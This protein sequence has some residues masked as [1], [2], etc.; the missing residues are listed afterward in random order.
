MTLPQSRQ[1]RLAPPLVSRRYVPLLAG[2]IVAAC[3]WWVGPLAVGI[4]T[5]RN[6]R[7]KAVFGKSGGAQ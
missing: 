6:E 1:Y 4:E 2:A 3:F 5:L 7:Q